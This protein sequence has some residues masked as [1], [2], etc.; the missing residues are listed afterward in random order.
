MSSALSARRHKSPSARRAVSPRGR[1]S[2]VG[3]EGP[4]S[5]I[6]TKSSWGN[7]VSSA[8][9]AGRYPTPEKIETPILFPIHD[10]EG[11][12]DL[13]DCAFVASVAPGDSDIL[14]CTSWHTERNTFEIVLDRVEKVEEGKTVTGKI[15]EVHWHTERANVGPRRKSHLVPSTLQVRNLTEVVRPIDD[16]VDSAG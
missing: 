1:P 6:E 12:P 9:S 14:A 5:T 11:V 13:F 15:S 8:P 10:H 7:T 4:L 2:Y 16:N 3:L